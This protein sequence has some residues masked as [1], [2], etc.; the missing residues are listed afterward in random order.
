VWAQHGIDLGG[1]LAEHRWPLLRVDGTP[2]EFS[3]PGRVRADGAGWACKLFL[4][5][6][7][8]H[9]TV[10]LAVEQGGVRLDVSLS[11]RDVPNLG[12][13]LNHRGW[14][15]LAGATPYMNLAFE[16]C[17]GA[18]DTLDAALGAWASAA[19]LR[20]GATRR[21]S[22]AWRAREIAASRD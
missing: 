6:P 3:R 21:W 10:R 19:W 18:A 17:I 14:T 11:P 1:A 8:Q 15:P 12:L 9:D 2:T 16:P 20:A 13:W 7:Q 5:L 4:D 22:L